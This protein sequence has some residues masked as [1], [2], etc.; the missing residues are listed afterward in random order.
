MF[1]QEEWVGIKKVL[2]PDRHKAVIVTLIAN[3]LDTEMKL[4][5]KH[6]E[7]LTDENSGRIFFG[8]APE[9]EIKEQKE[10]D[11]GLGQ[12]SFNDLPGIPESLLDSLQEDFRKDCVPVNLNPA[13]NFENNLSILL[14]NLKKFLL[15]KNKNYGNSA[16]EP[17]NIF[18]KSNSENSICQRLDDKLTRIKNSNELRK[19]DCVDLVGYMTLL[20]MSKDWLSFDEFID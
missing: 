19:N 16:L 17:I 1:T 12:V 6:S 10:S 9:Q 8:K 13:N 2:T 14:D 18:S 20:L 7:V 15:E 3:G 5:T 11:C 4:D